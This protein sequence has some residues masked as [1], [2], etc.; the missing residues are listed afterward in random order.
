MS[1]ITISGIGGES[2]VTVENPDA[3]LADA[4]ALAGINASDQ[5]L[6]VDAN[7]ARVTDPASVLVN[8]GDQVIT[9]P[10]EAKLGS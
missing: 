7:G 10:R 8:D 6:N 1:T 9:T 3:T 2:I 4:L 5:G